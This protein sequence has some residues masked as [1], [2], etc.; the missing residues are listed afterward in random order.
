MDGQRHYSPG[1]NRY[2]I[3][4]PK[5][6]NI[7]CTGCH[8]RVDARLTDGREI[9]PARPDLADLPFWICGMCG[10]YAGCHHKTHDRTRPLG[11]LATP[12]LRRARQII[13]AFIDPF[14]QTGR[15]ERWKLYQQISDA[16]GRSY[17][18]AEMYDVEEAKKVYRIAKAIERTLPEAKSLP[19]SG[20]WNK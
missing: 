11:M 3:V 17:H 18:T 19:P 1:F 12:E 14:W 15:I 9:Y 2:E 6:I 16:F 4:N 8:T 7:W 20:P 13:H 10:A 5:R